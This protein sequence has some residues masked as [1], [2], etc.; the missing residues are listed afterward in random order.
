MLTT[1]QHN[2]AQHITAHNSTQQHSAAHNSTSQ[3]MAAQ[4]STAQHS[5]RPHPRNAFPPKSAQH[6]TAQC[7]RAGGHA[8]VPF[9]P[10]PLSPFHPCTPSPLS[11]FHPFTLS[12]LRPFT[13][14]AWELLGAS[15][16][17]LGRRRFRPGGLV[18][19]FGVPFWGLV[20]ARAPKPIKSENS[21][22]RP[23]NQILHQKCM[24]SLRGRHF[25]PGGLVGAFG[26][27]FGAWSVPVR[28]NP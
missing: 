14:F 1:A 10:S 23:A 22:A 27:H 26:V 16:G 7:G 6:S 11:P 25:R 9:A 12:P 15:W 20:G 24:V 28:Q 8:R 19:A 13:P 4:R 17:H 5:A 18:G 3:H 2:T 21:L